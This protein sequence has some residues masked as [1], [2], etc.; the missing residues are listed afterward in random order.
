MS[1]NWVLD[2]VLDQMADLRVEYTVVI[3]V[4]IQDSEVD[5]KE[6]VDS[7]SLHVHTTDDGY[8]VVEGGG[9]S[10]HDSLELVVGDVEAS[11]DSMES[12]VHAWS[13]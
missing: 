2:H 9:R 3:R 1:Y 8:K 4:D 5:A 13:Y 10:S 11:R 7:E 6:L 12:S